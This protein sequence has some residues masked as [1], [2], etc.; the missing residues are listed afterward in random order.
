MGGFTSVTWCR[1]IP[2]GKDG[3]WILGIPVMMCEAQGM[4][5]ILYRLSILGKLVWAKPNKWKNWKLGECRLSSWELGS[6]ASSVV[7]HWA[8]LF[9]NCSNLLSMQYICWEIITKGHHPK[10]YFGRKR[11]KE[12]KKRKKETERSDGSYWGWGNPEK[13]NDSYAMAVKY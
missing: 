12:K 10:W 4:Q 2:E 8:F 9:P 13:E 1:G 5:S 7:S 11:K 6:A 3:K